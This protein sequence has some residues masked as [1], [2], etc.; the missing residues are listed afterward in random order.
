[1]KENEDKNI[2][3]YV[4]TVIKE[5]PLESPSHDFTAKVMANVL[6]TGKSKATIYRPLISKKGWLLVFAII[7]T[8][9]YFIVNGSSQSQQ[10]TWSFGPGLKNFLSNF[11]DVSLFQFSKITTSVI[12]LATIMIFIQI[13]WLKNHL[14]KR[15]EK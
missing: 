15:F 3:H 11:G 6:A 10:T 14:N 7:A 5:T 9:G 1:M 4:R 13:T 8:I 2:E 12:V